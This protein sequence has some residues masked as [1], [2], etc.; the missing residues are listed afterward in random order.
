MCMA[1]TLHGLLLQMIS[2]YHKF[3]AVVPKWNRLLSELWTNFTSH[4]CHVLTIKKISQWIHSSMQYE[5]H[6]TCTHQVH[7][8]MSY[9]KYTLHVHI[10]HTLTCHMRYTL[11]VHI[12]QVH[13]NMSHVVH[14]T[15]T[16]QV[17]SSMSYGV[18]TT[19]TYQV[20]SNMSY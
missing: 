2:H 16:Y 15:C 9:L 7:S 4:F 10:R 14:T 12:M 5:V 1:G 13:S 20:H 8:N 6:T 3:W 17:H 18:H 11:H 19:C